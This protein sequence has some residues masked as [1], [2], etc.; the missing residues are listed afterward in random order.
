ME[1]RE[2][3]RSRGQHTMKSITPRQDCRRQRAR[4][5]GRKC[6]APMVRYALYEWF[7][8][9]RFAIDWRALIAENRSRGKKYFAR[10]PMAIVKLKTHQLLAE[11]ASASLLNGETPILF[12]P[13]S[14]WFKRWQEE[15]GLS[16]RR[17]NRKCAVPR[18]VLKQRL[19]IF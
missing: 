2:S 13:S 9:L 7:T 4:G 18:N 17:A 10:F 6:K 12:K 11:F 14:H 5:A 16:M 8:A 3:H 15:F 1:K 19:E